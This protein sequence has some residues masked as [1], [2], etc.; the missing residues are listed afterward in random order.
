MTLRNPAS[1]FEIYVNDME[2][3]RK[4]YETVMGVET[5]KMEAGDFDGE[6]YTLPMVMGGEGAGG[7][8]V[9]WANQQP[10]SSGT[11]VYF[12]SKD[13]E[14]ELARV[15]GAG[16]KILQTKSQAGEFGFSCLIQDTEGNTVGFF[17]KNKNRVVLWRRL[18]QFTRGKMFL[19]F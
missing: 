9:K 2:R 11:I 13:C 5:T 4:F 15:E 1:W 10:S 17:Q 8:L 14:I 18:R 12:D 7:A 3:A 19:N 16:G 6:M